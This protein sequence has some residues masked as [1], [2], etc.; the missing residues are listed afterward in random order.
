MFH[1]IHYNVK[2]KSFKFELCLIFIKLQCLDVEMEYGFEYIGSSTR[3]VITPQTERCF[4]AMTQSVNAYM[5]TLCV[6]P[7]VSSFVIFWLKS[8]YLF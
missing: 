8:F 6:G 1:K 3:E 4:V 7:I 2:G 5:G